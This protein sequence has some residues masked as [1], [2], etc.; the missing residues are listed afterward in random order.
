MKRTV[1]VVGMVAMIAGA[2]FAQEVLLLKLE[3]LFYGWKLGDSM[4]SVREAMV[5][6]PDDT[7]EDFIFYNF[8]LLC[9]SMRFEFTGGKLWSVTIKTAAFDWDELVRECVFKHFGEP[10]AASDDMTAWAFDDL[11]VVR[12]ERKPY[13]I[14]TILAFNLFVGGFGE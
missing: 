8:D 9:T 12:L 10:T 2:V 5:A 6:E 4:E 1:I 3:H 14:I 7:G 11:S 13:E